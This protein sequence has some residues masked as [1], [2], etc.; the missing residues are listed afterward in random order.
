[1]LGFKSG[2]NDGGE[3]NFLIGRKDVTILQ[4]MLSFCPDGV[5]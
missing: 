3:Y 4:K 1:M 5:V 2:S